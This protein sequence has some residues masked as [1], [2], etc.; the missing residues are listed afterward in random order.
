MTECDTCQ[1]RM[2]LWFDDRLTRP[3]I[4]Q[5]EA[6]I[7]TCPSC[8]TSLDALRRVDRMLAVAPVMSPTPGFTARFQSR[9]AAR[10]RRHRTWAGLF[11]LGVA[12]LCLLLGATVLL[13]VPGLA[14]WENLSTSGLLAH[15][16]GLLL[17]LA[18]AWATL[19]KLAWLIVGALARG[20][21]HPIFIAYIV[22]TAIL[23]V[24]WTEIVTRRGL[25]HHPATIDLQTR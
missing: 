22:V 12:T 7:A 4:Q 20:L 24:T 19:L 1:K 18:K 21:R 5:V 6:H 8:R 16:I 3:E 13:A 2:S 10:R 15:G 23:T 17:D 11:I 9:L 14:L 25:V